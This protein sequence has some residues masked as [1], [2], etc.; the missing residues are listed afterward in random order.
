M[1]TEPTIVDL[2]AKPTVQI[3]FTLARARMAELLPPR[4]SEL[5]GA[6]QQAGVHGTEPWFLFLHPPD[7]AAPDQLDVAIGVPVAPNT[8]VDPVELTASELPAARAARARYRGPYDGLPAA[9][10]ALDA[11][12]E[13]N[14]DTPRGDLW[15]QY[16]KGPNDTG[17]DTSKL[18]TELTR[19]LR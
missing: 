17:G 9:W 8:E 3:R 1:L 12:I 13:H 7:P 18:L 14:G 10:A 16:L 4:V 6:L 15:E 19:P 11:W 5:F 2:T